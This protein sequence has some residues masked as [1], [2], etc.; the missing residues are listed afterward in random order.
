MPERITASKT[1]FGPMIIAA[2]EQYFPKT[3]RLVED[4]LAVDFLPAGV[5]LVVRSCRWGF[6]RRA[7][8]NL[9]EKVSPGTWAGIAC[10][11]RYIDE[12][13]SAAIADGLRALVILG[14]GLDT[15]AC[16][17]AAPKGVRAYEV[18]Q[19]QSIDYKGARMRARFGRVPENVSLVAVDFERDDLGAAL[20]ENGFPIEMPAIFVWEGVTQYLTEEAVRRTFAFLAKA[21][22]G[23]RMVFTYVRKD[24]LDGTNLFGMEKIYRRS[25]ER[26]W[27][28]GVAPE[29]VGGLLNEYGWEEREQAGHAEFAAR[30]IA[31]TGRELPV[32]AIER[33]VYAEKL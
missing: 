17:L 14:A 10:R 19:P 18:D 7:L 21:G 26:L 13:V 8:M 12:K 28:Y 9:A 2:C 6:F 27:H 25:V 15:R 32:F 30:Y 23:S 22:A 3:Q 11:K 31:P 29:A 5:K 16:R 4:N 33:C 20:A 1:A 24:F